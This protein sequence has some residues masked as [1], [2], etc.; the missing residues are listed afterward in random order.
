MSNSVLRLIKEK[1]YKEAKNR[2][3]QF[4]A[5][6]IVKLM[7]N[8]SDYELVVVFSLL[9]KWLTADVFAVDLRAFETGSH[10][11]QLTFYNQYAL[12]VI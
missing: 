12:L 11:F 6:E 2:L 3:Q 4:P 7:D 9:P 5:T 1:K 10:Q 8:F